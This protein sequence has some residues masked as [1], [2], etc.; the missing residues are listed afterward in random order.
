M[1]YSFSSGYGQAG[2]GTT[3]STVAGIGPG[4]LD[5]TGV[6]DF[7]L[8]LKG[9]DFVGFGIQ[10]FRS[11]SSDHAMLNLFGARGTM[12]NP[13]A[14]VIGDNVSTISSRAYTGSS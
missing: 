1:V 4:K 12:S 7:T 11:S 13:S 9:D 3:P 2:I 10:S 6:G 8:R 5:I 14:L